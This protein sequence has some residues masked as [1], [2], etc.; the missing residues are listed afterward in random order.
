MN[1]SG[2]KEVMEQDI[3]NRQDALAARDEIRWSY[4]ALSQ[5][6]PVIYVEE[7]EDE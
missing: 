6:M 7:Y 1:Q 5:Q 4:A 2:H 3:P